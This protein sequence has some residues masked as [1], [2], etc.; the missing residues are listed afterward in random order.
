M[1]HFASSGEG[2]LVTVARG[3][4]LWM[5]DYGS[6]VVGVY[7][8]HQ[9]SLRRVPHLNVGTESLRNLAL[10]SQDIRLLNWDYQSTKEFA[11][12]TQLL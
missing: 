12:K 2:L 4:L 11:A 9:D 7:T 5:Q 1:A 8:W 3:Q 10:R 6:P